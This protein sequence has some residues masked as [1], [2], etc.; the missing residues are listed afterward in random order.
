[1]SHTETRVDTLHNT[2][3]VESG[4]RRR[5]SLRKAVA[6]V[7]LLA[8]PHLAAQEVL[9]LDIDGWRMRWTVGDIEEA[10]DVVARRL[11]LLEPSADPQR[12]AVLLNRRGVFTYFLASRQDKWSD[13]QPLLQSAH[14]DFLKASDLFVS[15]NEKSAATSNAGMTHQRLGRYE[16]AE[17]AYRQALTTHDEEPHAANNLGW[18]LF[19][20]KGDDD[21]AMKLLGKAK[22]NGSRVAIINRAAVFLT[23]NRFSEARGE[24]ADIL[25]DGS[26]EPT[27]RQA[28]L[29]NL[30][31]IHRVEGPLGSAADCYRRAAEIRPKDPDAQLRLAATRFGKGEFVLA[32]SGF[33]KAAAAFRT[34]RNKG[35]AALLASIAL[36]RARQGGASRADLVRITKEV[37]DD[38]ELQ[39]TEDTWA[40]FLLKYMLGEVSNRELKA[41]LT[42]DDTPEEKARACEIFFA[43]GQRLLILSKDDN[44]EASSWL[45]RAV[46]SGADP[47]LIEHSLARWELDR[48]DQ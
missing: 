19:K 18:L 40:G 47:L 46:E 28:A 34:D 21:E 33:K 12:T 41:Q 26:V 45:T 20:H 8:V 30:G 23:Q 11:S 32:A 25:D 44:D 36:G 42:T 16:E 4:R 43:L 13:E 37:V 2:L 14:A 39:P 10:L 3:T 22:R 31:E 48:W 15:K 5:T 7:L 29:L 9:T 27:L 17:E 6:T 1:M 38:L 35:R 24:I